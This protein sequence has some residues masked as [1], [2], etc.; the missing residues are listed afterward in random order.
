MWTWQ[1]C[2]K[3]LSNKAN[4]QRHIGTMHRK[5][6]PF[7]CEFCEYAFSQNSSLTMHVTAVHEKRKPFI[8]EF[9]EYAC[10]LKSSLTVHVTAVHEK[11][12]LFICEFCEYACSQKGNLTRHV[13]MVHEKR[14][15]FTVNVNSV[16]LHALWSVICQNMYTRYSWKEKA[17]YMWIPWICRLWKEESNE[18]YQCGSQKVKTV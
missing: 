9:C 6:R 2:Q 16:N 17:F 1:E 4:L 13:M 12:K 7:I 5:L 15:S 11:R 10:S 8:C 14:K 3:S 18:T